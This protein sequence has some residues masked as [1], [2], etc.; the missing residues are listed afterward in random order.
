MYE[1]RLYE[2]KLINQQKITLLTSKQN[3]KTYFAD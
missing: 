2:I 1:D 3:A